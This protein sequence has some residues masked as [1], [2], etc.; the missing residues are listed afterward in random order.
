MGLGMQT[1]RNTLLRRRSD[2]PE[3]GNRRNRRDARRG[4]DSRA[5]WHARPAEIEGDRSPRSRVLVPNP[6]SFR[7]DSPKVTAISPSGGFLDDISRSAI[8]MKKNSDFLE[9]ERARSFPS[10]VFEDFE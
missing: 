7:A 2:S 3:F 5:G 4:V 8:E 1:A 10:R 9:P 6:R